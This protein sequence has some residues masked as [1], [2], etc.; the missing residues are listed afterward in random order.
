MHLQFYPISDRFGYGFGVGTYIPVA[1]P[2]PMFWNWGKPKPSQSGK[3]PS[4]WIWYGW[5]PAGMDFVACLLLVTGLVS[6]CKLGWKIRGG[7]GW[8]IIWE[9][10]GVIEVWERGVVQ[11]WGL[12]RVVGEGEVGGWYEEL[13]LGGVFWCFEVGEEGW[14]I[15]WVGGLWFGSDWVWVK[16]WLMMQG[17]KSSPR[18]VYVVGLGVCIFE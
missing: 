16:R 14:Y 17:D 7:D 4:K 8:F 13:R 3:Y 15:W 9:C 1:L 6:V 5:V 11:L 12:G 2:V 18:N 10:D